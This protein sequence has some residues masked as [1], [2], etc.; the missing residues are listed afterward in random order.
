MPDADEYGY[1]A[2]DSLRRELEEARHALTLARQELN[3]VT[4]VLEASV[5]L[6]AEDEVVEEL[7]EPSPPQS[8]RRRTPQRKI[9]TTTS[10]AV[11]R[12]TKPAQSRARLPES[13]VRTSGR[14]VVPAGA[15]E[16]APSAK[17]AP[18]KLPR[19]EDRD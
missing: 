13:S 6:A 14:D 1:S 11:A 18:R 12:Q 9:E 15:V 3:R 16:V 19:F 17:R 7:P 2:N 4:R 8:A 5:A 10:V